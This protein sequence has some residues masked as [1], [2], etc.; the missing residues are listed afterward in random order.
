VRLRAAPKQQRK[1]AQDQADK[2]LE[3]EWPISTAFACTHAD[4]HGPSG[5]RTNVATNQLNN[6]LDHVQIDSLNYVFSIYYRF[7][8]PIL[9]FSAAIACFTR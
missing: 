3:L 4:P 6:S 7:K 8:I 5:R 2:K 1:L 9:F